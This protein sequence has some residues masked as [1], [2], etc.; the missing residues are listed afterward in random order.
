MPKT[1]N[2]YTNER[3]LEIIELAEKSS[4]RKAGAEYGI[5]ESVIRNWRKSKEVV[6]KSNLKRRTLRTGTSYWPEL[7]IELKIWVL[8]ERSNGR[9]VEYLK[10]I[11]KARELAKKSE[12]LNFKGTLGWCQRFMKRHSLRVRAVTSVG[13]PLP[14]DWEAK[15]A[16]FKCFIESNRIGIISQHIGNMDEVPMSFDLPSKFTI[17][18]LGADSVKI[19]T[20]GAEKCNFT[21]AL[22]ITADGGKLSPFVIFKRKTL[23]KGK[24]FQKEIFLKGLLLERRKRDG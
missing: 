11:R 19:S 13:Q 4:N 24:H 20:T 8:N 1:R 23:P 21:V 16:K 10:I 5:N 6:L 2:S 18:C 22:A 15:V 7:E 3:K 12:I 17:D 14:D 9:R